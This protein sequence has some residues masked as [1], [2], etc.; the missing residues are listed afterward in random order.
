MLPNYHDHAE[1]GTLT[2]FPLERA[3]FRNA[4]FSWC[5]D[6]ARECFARSVIE[7]GLR[8]DYLAGNMAR[9]DCAPLS[10][11]E[12]E[13]HLQAVAAR[14]PLPVVK[15]AAVGEGR[16]RW[17]HVLNEAASVG[18]HTAMAARWI[19]LD[20]DS[21][22][23][24]VILLGQRCPV[25]PFLEEAVARSGGVLHCLD[26][27]AS[28]L[29]R[30]GQLRNYA[31]QEADVVVLHIN[32]CDVM[33][34]VAFAVP[35]GPPVLLV[36]HAAHVFWTGCTITDRVLNCRGSALEHD[37]TI[38]HRGI[39]ASRS[40][41]LPIPLLPA[42]EQTPGAKARARQ[43]LALPEDARI[44]LTVGST[45][46][47]KPLPGIDFLD[48]VR[49]ILASGERV[50]L[51]A[52]GVDEDHRWAALKQAT[53]GRLLAVGQ[54]RDL[55]PFHAAADLY[56][57][58]FPFGS[59]TSLLEAGLQGLACVL[60]PATCPPPFG[61]DGPAVDVLPRPVDINA[62]V[63]AVR[64]LL[65]DDRL[66]VATGR[67]LAAA[68][69]SH[70]CGAGWHGYLQALKEGLPAGHQV[71]AINPAIPVR[72]QMV[73]YWSA[74]STLVQPDPIGYLFQQAFSLKLKP[75]FD[76]QLRNAV[77]RAKSFRR[78]GPV[79]DLF[80][81]FSASLAA[82]VPQVASSSFYGGLFDCF[83]PGSRTMRVLGKLAILWR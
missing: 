18:G 77:A 83:R 57:E 24:S 65:E 38:R 12:L 63:D 75:R 35:G 82:F 28:L 72:E 36:N 34:T 1:P 20:P 56:M 37:W 25:P 48:A 73:A 80:T 10:S 69:A 53:G 5:L 19:A 3:A 29:E 16:P 33:A 71:Y 78:D 22:R 52:V 2:D 4:I 32:T 76:G 15:H 6:N 45:F 79:I 59:T 54:Q 47:Y 68:I 41:T 14:L 66:R 46:K 30:A 21:C 60:A 58:G 42:V 62:Y 51:V 39:S 40:V 11:P 13:A 64:E 61:T 74:F 7:E 8:W 31:W 67:L 26:P 50:Y 27:A 70:H 43:Q 55:A 17:L 49:R 44:V 9:M 81:R 23:Q